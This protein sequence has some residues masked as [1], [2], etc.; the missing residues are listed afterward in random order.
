M[1][2][3]NH[4][5]QGKLWCPR[6]VLLA[7]PLIPG[8]QHCVPNEHRNIWINRVRTCDLPMGNNYKDF[9]FGW[10]WGLVA[11]WSQARMLEHDLRVLD[12]IF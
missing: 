12:F 2:G 10:C 3:D 1:S 9:P 11:H 6:N 5:V 4:G 7:G 8:A